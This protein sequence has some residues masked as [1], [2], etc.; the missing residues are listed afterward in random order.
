MSALKD[1]RGYHP[2]NDRRRSGNSRQQDNI[3]GRVFQVRNVSSPVNNP[4]TVTVSPQNRFVHR[5]EPRLQVCHAVSETA[6]VLFAGLVPQ[7]PGDDFQP[8][9]PFRRFGKMPLPAVEIDDE[10]PGHP[11]ARFRTAAFLRNRRASGWALP[12][13]QK[14]RQPGIQTASEQ[15][16]ESRMV[17]LDQ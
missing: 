14:T 8:Q 17:R 3:R 11:D 15:V 13:R 2:E 9:S 7:T 16:E 6:V 12:R 1:S 4:V 5:N 10:F